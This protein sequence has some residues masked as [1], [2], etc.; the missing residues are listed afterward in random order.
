MIV[1][2]EGIDG[3]GK[4]TQLNLAKNKFKNA[5]ITKEPGGTKLGE[6]LRDILLGGEF[7]LAKNAELFLFLAD[8]AQHAKELLSRHK[9]SLI[10]SDR[11]TISGIA[12]AMDSFNLDELIS[13]NR[14][15]LGEAM[16]NAVVFLKASKELLKER[17]AKRG[18]SDVIESRGL[19]YLL[20]IQENMKTAIKSLNISHIEIDAAK[21]AQEISKM[22]NKFIK[23][24]L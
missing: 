2:F 23:E 1:L 18:T 19:E 24:Q 8:R 11:G 3:V 10:L 5:I 16:P 20:Q 13:L 17:L 4:S 7:K 6:R 22:I 15:A 9:N 14:L 21:D 12:Y